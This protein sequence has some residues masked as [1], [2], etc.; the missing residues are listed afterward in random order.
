MSDAFA[1][2]GNAAAG[3]LSEVFAREATDAT[4]CCG[5]CGH[6]GPLAELVCYGATASLVL[7]CPDCDAVNLRIMQA[8]DKLQVD[9]SGAARIT[10]SLAGLPS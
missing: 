7:R 9:C 2:D 10:F 4:L 3:L 1:L 5:A 6:S 8:P